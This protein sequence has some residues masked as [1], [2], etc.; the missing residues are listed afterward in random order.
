[1]KI[2]GAPNA[3]EFAILLGIAKLQYDPSKQTIDI[4]F[5][6]YKFQIKLLSI[7]FEILNF[8]NLDQIT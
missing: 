4:D 2:I 3:I 5:S 1:M 8:P 6:I 7:I